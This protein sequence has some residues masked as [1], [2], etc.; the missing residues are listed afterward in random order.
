MMYWLF[1][2]GFAN[3]RRTALSFVTKRKITFIL[4]SIFIILDETV[5][6]KHRDL[7]PV[8]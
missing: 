5:V 1:L 8:L 2:W 6:V 7:F 3:F 4:A